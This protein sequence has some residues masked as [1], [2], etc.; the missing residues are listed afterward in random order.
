MHQDKGAPNLN[1]T[2]KKYSQPTFEIL[3]KEYLELDYL[4]LEYLLLLLFH[5]LVYCILW[6]Q[7]LIIVSRKHRKEFLYEGI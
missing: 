4:E 5:L 7:I 1:Y 3:Q 2:E 6:K